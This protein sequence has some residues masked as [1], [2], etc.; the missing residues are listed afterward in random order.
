MTA[1]GPLCSSEIIFES[2][3]LALKAHLALPPGGGKNCPAVV[4]AHG[5]PSGPGGGANSP[6]TFP[7]LAERMA[8]EMG[9]VVMVP[10]LRGMPG[11]EG[12]FSLQG[13]RD[14]LL[15]AVEYLVGLPE[16]GA[17]WTAGFGTGGALAVCAGAVDLRVNGVAAL[18]TPADFND[19][20]DNPRRLLLHARKA[21]LVDESAPPKGFDE[22]KA[23]LSDISAELAVIQ[24]AP[25]PLLVV[26]GSDDEVVPPLDAR[27]LSGTHGAGELRM[28]SGAGHHLRHDP[29]AIAVL[30]GWLDRQQRE[31]IY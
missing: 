14:D 2:E 26:H 1:S 8:A 23:S 27:L 16:V 15:A 28:I 17:V 30:L 25:R 13:W 4:I 11:S 12:S 3:S 21:G 5:F 29:R 24:L 6:A 10:Y 19:W 31:L 18:A 9:W 20:A 7:E 22:W